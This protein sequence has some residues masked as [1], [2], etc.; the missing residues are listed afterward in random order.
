MTSKPKRGAAAGMMAIALAAALP[1][2]AQAQGMSEP[3]SWEVAIYG[4]FPAIGGSTS[5]PAT[6]TGP[7]ID[8]SAADV[9][10][11]LKMAFMGQIEVRQGKWGL[12]SDLV[13]ANFGASKQRSGIS[14]GNL[15]VTV[16]A[17]LVLDIKSTIWS[18]AGVYNIESTE[19]STA[20]LVFGT[21]LLDMQQTLGWSLATDI[22]QLPGRNGSASADITNWDAII[23]VKGRY[24][25]GDE[26]KWFVPYYADI[27]TGQSK[28]TWQVYAGVGYKFDWGSVFAAWR[29]LDYDFKSGSA[30]QSLS[31]NGAAIGVAFQF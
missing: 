16:D 22:P 29:Y 20:D 18:L 30:I 7:S 11:A 27:G 5:F 6:G 31:M 17:N 9:L 1:L 23:G 15:P 2:Q 3:Y 12:W 4:W 24:F 8:V 19:R 25:L 21:R 14:V 13:Y 28:F 10:D 26:R